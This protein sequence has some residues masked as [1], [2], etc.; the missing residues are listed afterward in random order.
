MLPSLNYH[1]TSGVVFS[2]LDASYSQDESGNNS[3]VADRMILSGDYVTNSARPYIMSL[4]MEF[5]NVIDGSDVCN[6]FFASA[7]CEFGVCWIIA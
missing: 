2:I 4:S 3:L 5:G 7:I 6:K 1:H